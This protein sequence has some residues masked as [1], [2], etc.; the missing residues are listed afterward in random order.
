MR[1]YRL[2]DR[3]AQEAQYAAVNSVKVVACGVAL[4]LPAAGPHATAVRTMS[5]AAA[6]RSRREGMRGAP[7][8]ANGRDLGPLDRMTHEQSAHY[9]MRARTRGAGAPRPMR[10]VRRTWEA[11]GQP[12]QNDPVFS[13]FGG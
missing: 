5:S 11:C 3:L 2:V 9:R 13:N 8:A 7:M 10:L 1:G 6:A 4:G 12:A